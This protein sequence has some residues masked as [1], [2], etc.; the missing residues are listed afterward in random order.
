VKVCA[1]GGQI[2]SAPAPF[3]ELPE[4]EPGQDL[5]RAGIAKQHSGW[6]NRFGSQQLKDA[7]PAEQARSVGRELQ[8]GA[9]RL[10]PGCLLEETD[11]KAALRECQCRCQPGN[12]AP[13]DNNLPGKPPIHDGRCQAAFSI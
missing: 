4:R 5:Q 8:A 13:G 2:W 7:Q 11:V 9:E 1:M 10:E 12:P 6:L 3:G